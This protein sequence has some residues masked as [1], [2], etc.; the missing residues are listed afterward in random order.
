V[1]VICSGFIRDNGSFVH[2]CSIA[3]RGE[4]ENGVANHGNRRPENDLT[5]EVR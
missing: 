2:V 1:R 4:P 5:A 3:A